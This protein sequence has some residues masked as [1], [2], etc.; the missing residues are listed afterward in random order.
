MSATLLAEK[1]SAKYL[2][3]PPIDAFETLA[4]VAG[5]VARIRELVAT[6]AVR[7]RLITERTGVTSGSELVAELA[8][9]APESAS[10]ARGELQPL[11]DDEEP[12]ALPATWAWARLGQIADITGG[13]TLGRKSAI[14]HP[15]TL[16]YLRVANV[17]R[18]ALLLESNVKT[19]TV[20]ATEL[21]RYQLRFGDLL[22][23]EGGDWDKVG[24][25]C[26]WRDELPTCL[27]QNHVFRIRG[28]TTD[29][30]PEW[31]ALYLN[32]AD[33]RA[34]FAACA[35]Q[36]TNLASINMTELRHCVIPVPPLSVQRSI[37]ARVQELMQLCDTLEANGRLADEQHARLTSTL[38]EALAAS[39]S[40]HA[41]AENWERVTAC[42]DL[43]LDRGTAV[44]AL[45]STVLQLALKG[46]L[47]EQD[48]QE[49]PAVSLLR[50]LRQTQAQ[51]LG[52][53]RIR[54]EKA[55]PKISE[56]EVPFALPAGWSWARLSE[57]A[58]FIDYR[59]RTPV[60]TASG[61]PLITAKNVRKGFISREPR[62]FIAEDAYD[63]WMTRGFPKAGDLLFTTEAPL[64]H[65]AAIDISERFALA[66]RVI[67]LGLF[68]PKMSGVMLLFLQSTWMQ[69][70][71]EAQASGVTAQG[72]K[73]ARLQLLLVPIPPL[74]EQH[75][76]AARVAELRLLCTT[77]R[78][79]LTQARLTQ[80][81]L[82]DAL[83]DA[84]LH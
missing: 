1:P 45:E 48:Q 49:V 3:A 38:F 55:I 27:H 69:A 9:A 34:Y 18:N 83:V 2:V 15:L 78:A 47:V 82:A 75:R 11:S 5:G 51:M 21:P 28:R 23:I 80:S 68:E 39:E 40:A 37:V 6:L 41:L 44:D 77:L 33:A 63:G 72:I 50:E 53:G 17:Q 7:G 16:P 24:R 32:S 20:D 42:F 26:I 12:F 43:L 60:K 84:A 57:L 4:N 73:S 19:V 74:A 46:L 30:M 71:F 67:C 52:D 76:I 10:R 8:A 62:E 56:A 54:R 22:V 65:V 35:K 64:G 36:T 14:P 66:Q 25:T 31:F 58:N 70:C 29:W 79:R 13:V 61:V 59:G 81:Q